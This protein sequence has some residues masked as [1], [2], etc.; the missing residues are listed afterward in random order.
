MLMFLNLVNSSRLYELE[1]NKKEVFR[2]KDLIH[3][4]Q[5][6]SHF[7]AASIQSADT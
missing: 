7:T 2:S 6:N 3:V 4:G 1:Q 5:M